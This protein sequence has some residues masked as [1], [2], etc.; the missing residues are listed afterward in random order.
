MLRLCGFLDLAFFPILLLLSYF[1]KQHC[2]KEV[3]K[4]SRLEYVLADGSTL[5]ENG[6]ESEWTFLMS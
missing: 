6:R 5:I 4:L 2:G 1:K 3:C